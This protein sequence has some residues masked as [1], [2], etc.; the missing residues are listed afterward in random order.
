MRMASP[1]KPANTSTPRIDGVGKVTGAAE[2]T[3]D[4]AIE[5]ALWAKVLRSP[6]AHARI[7]RVDASKAR[8]FPG[9]HA[10]ITGDDVP[11][12]LSGRRI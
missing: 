1:E 6:H 5:G 10:V 8:A 9:V 4:V 7:T 3:A 2:Y 11:R 12:V